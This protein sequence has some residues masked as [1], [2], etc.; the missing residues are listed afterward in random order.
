MI[1]A[2]RWLAPLAL[3]LLVAACDPT[4]DLDGPLKPMGEFRLGHNIAVAR[5][6]TLAPGSLKATEAEWQA[7][8]T[9]AVADRFGRYEGDRLY[10][11]GISID[12]YNLSI[13]DAPLLPTPKPIL[14][15]TASIWDDALGRKLNAEAKQ[16]TVI[17]GT[18][19]GTGVAPSREEQM[20]NLSASG[21]EA[22]QKWVM[23]N[24]QRFQPGGVD[25]AAPAN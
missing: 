18:L 9:K 21:A 25:A 4:T 13:L 17:G 6:P 15:I 2:F 5:N 7:A 20:A 23:E 11:I 22:V 10:H 16:L 24:R 3:T 14:I 12:G 8:M 1:R 19:A